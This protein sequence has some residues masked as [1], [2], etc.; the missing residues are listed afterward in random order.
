LQTAEIIT[1]AVF[2]VKPL[3]NTSAASKNNGI[4]IL[5]TDILIPHISFMVAHFQKVLQADIHKNQTPCDMKL[6]I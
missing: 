4:S 3:I 5:F 6:V 2:S 1:P